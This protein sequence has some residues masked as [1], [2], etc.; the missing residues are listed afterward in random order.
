[1]PALFLRSI[2]TVKF[3]ETQPFLELDP[4]FGHG[5]LRPVNS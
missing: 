5:I 2:L 1:L 4:I 3:G